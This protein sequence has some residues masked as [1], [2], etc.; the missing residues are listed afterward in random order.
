M[1]V[2]S[3]TF[4]SSALAFVRANGVPVFV[5][6]NEYDMN[7][8]MESVEAAIGPKTKAIVCVHYAVCIDYSSNYCHLLL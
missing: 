1:I 5:D 7:M 8:N 2:P 6:S 3:Y 4:V